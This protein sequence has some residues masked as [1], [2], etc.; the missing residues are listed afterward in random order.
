M[1]LVNT[2]TLEVADVISYQKQIIG[3]QLSAGVFDFLGSHFFDISAG[4]SALEPIQLAVRSVIERAV[5]EMITRI[6]RAPGNACSIPINNA[7][8]PLRDG[9]YGAPAY[10]QPAGY[11][12]APAPYYPQPYPQQAYYA[13]PVYAYG[14]S[15]R[16]GAYS[17]Y[18]SGDPVGDMRLRGGM[19]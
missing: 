1:R 8:D 13:P 14:P 12:P 19:E 9:Y 2:N 17:G 10:V 5:L 18:S 4:E 3:R 11:G 16:G 6:Y 7:A 15:R